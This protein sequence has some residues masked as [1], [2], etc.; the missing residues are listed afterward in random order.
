MR[1]MIYGELK[2]KSETPNSKNL[3]W[4]KDMTIHEIFVSSYEELAEKTGMSP[5]QLAI[6][7]FSIA[8]AFGASTIDCPCCDSVLD[9]NYCIEQFNANRYIE[10]P[11]CG[12]KLEKTA[13]FNEKI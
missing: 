6:L 13:F 9:I 7:R 2:E 5:E 8:K 11:F 3:K 4:T 1:F 10:C 12:A